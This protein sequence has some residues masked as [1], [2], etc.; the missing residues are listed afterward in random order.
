VTTISGR[1][2]VLL[3]VLAAATVLAVIEVTSVLAI[4][5][6]RPFLDEEIR[7][8]RDVFREQSE[9]IEKLLD[10]EV[11]R[12]L[13]LDPRLGWRYRAGYRD[14]VNSISVQ[15]L[16]GARE[17]ARKPAPGTLRVAAYGDS[18]V[19][20][21][22]VVDSAAWPAQAER[23]FPG[24]EVLNYGVGGYGVD[25]AY[26]RYCLEGSAL[27]PQ[28]VIIGFAT[29]DMRRVVN[30]YR[31]FI[32]NRELP[33]VKPRFVLD[34]DGLLQAVSVPLPDRG[35][36]QRYLR[37]PED[38][39]HLG[40]HD[41]WYAPAIYGNP[42]YDYSATVRLVTNVW[43]RIAHR[44]FDADRLFRG[45]EFNSSSSV[46]RLQGAVFAAFADAVRAA[47]ARPIVV[48][49]PDR[50]SVVRAR[51]GGSTV[52]APLVRDLAARGLEHIDLT[53]A[54]V[55]RDAAGEVADWFQPGGHYSGAGNR[56]VAAALGEAVLEGSRVPRHPTGRRPATCPVTGA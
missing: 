39:T 17:Y 18:F 19:Y 42:L 4:W 33:L 55:R 52:F 35:T 6:S 28:I 46:F 32:S 26:L 37:S 2:R 31:R 3:R 54:F 36:Y 47:G 43:A 9:L 48:L 50:E 30:V 11:P 56:I 13:T 27:S 51:N 29:D 14:S 1:R 23:L 45:G 5:L 34:G 16:R 15:G 20:G 12:L 21:T 40:A 41:Q 24:L 44:Y 25:Q 22:E 7:T 38:V 10:P 49:F 8:T 53:A